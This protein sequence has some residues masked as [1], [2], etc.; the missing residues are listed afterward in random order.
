MAVEFEM[1]PLRHAI[2][3][4]PDLMRPAMKADPFTVELL[5]SLD[6]RLD[7]A[8]ADLVWWANALALARAQSATGAD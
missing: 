8:A 7:R 4:L 3:I 5:A 2:H 1:A 6:E